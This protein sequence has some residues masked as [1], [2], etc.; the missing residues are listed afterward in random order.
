MIDNP[1]LNA[2]RKYLRLFDRFT[3]SAKSVFAE[4]MIREDYSRLIAEVR[5]EFEDILL[6]VPDIGKKQPFTDLLAFTAMYLA[7]YRVMQGQGYTAEQVGGVIWEINSAV[8]EAMPRVVLKIFGKRIF[9]PS[10]SQNLKA[11]AMQSQAREYCGDYVYEYVPGE[12]G[13]FDFGVDYLQCGGVEFLRQMGAPELA[14]FLCPVDRIY[15]RMFHWGLRRTTTLAEGGPCC[16]FRFRQGGAT[17]VTVP[18]ALEQY[19]Q[20]KE[21]AR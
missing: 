16:D 1:I 20:Q 2:K 5:Q 7:F 19:L 12:Q 21:K 4:R 11:R 18:A 6:Q 14:P 10:Y 17:E 13:A 15:S 3:R 8:M 9:T